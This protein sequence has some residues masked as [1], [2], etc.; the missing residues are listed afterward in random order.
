M[1]SEKKNVLQ[2]LALLKAYGIDKIVLSPGNRNVP[3]V[4]SI[5]MDPYFT[6][7]SVVDER[8]AAFFALGLIMKTQKPV[9]ICCTS[10]TSLMNYG[11]A[12]AE[13]F[14]QKLPL[15]VISA[16][17]SQK[18][19]GQNEGQL[20]PQSGIYNHIVKKCVDIDE[21]L[22]EEDEWY[23]NRLINEALLEL[24]HNGKGPVHINIEIWNKLYNFTVPQLPV[25]R[26]ISRFTLPTL[27]TELQHYANILKSSKKRMI[28][29][30]QS[31]PIN[32][33]EVA[34]LN[35][36]LKKFN[37]I[38]F[39]ESLSNLHHKN[40]I[41]NFER[42]LIAKTDLQKRELKPDLVIT[43]NGFF[44]NE[45]AIKE[46]NRKYPSNEHWHTA[47]DGAVCD[48]FKCLSTI[49]EGNIYSILEMF[50]QSISDSEVLND[51]NFISKW[52]EYDKEMTEKEYSYNYSDMYV[53][54]QFIKVLHRNRHYTLPIVAAS[55]YHNFLVL[56]NRY[57]FSAIEALT[58]LMDHSQLLLDM[59]H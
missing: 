52:K 15:V 4:H 22:T 50:T 11:S 57:K 18:Y 55:D 37:C 54:Q 29:F 32:E 58:V 26:K 19:K 48:Q 3:I 27:K 21:V 47:E 20:I 33:K 45:F 9:A 23:C 39:A 28:V 51:N 36:F 35:N 46:F 2:L 7:Y 43:M 56:M 16:D 41:G 59:L 6:C 30:G 31:L 42:L 49:F 10:G 44:I 14:Y 13:A 12:I 17:K 1:Y 40:V 38:I 53:V 24:D 34:I 5:E 8:S 25:V